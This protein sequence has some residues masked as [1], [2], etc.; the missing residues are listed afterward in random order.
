MATVTSV[1]KGG[2]YGL[3]AGLI[4][5][6]F[7]VVL[8]LPGAIIRISG[9]AVKITATDPTTWQL[10]N[11]MV[12]L[13]YS[14]TWLFLAIGL[15]IAFPG[16]LT[17]IIALTTSGVDRGQQVGL[18][19]AFTACLKAAVS[20]I[21]WFLIIAI[22]FSL[23]T[24]GI[25]T[26][27]IISAQ[28]LGATLPPGDMADLMIMGSNE[29]YAVLLWVVVLASSMAMVLAPAGCVLRAGFDPS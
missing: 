6:I 16:A 27:G 22:P 3:I 7:L 1:L 15:V 11:D 13:G 5:A 20:A 28:V 25:I 29:L 19:G 21:I 12:N 8:Y 23:I 4:W 9:R 18:R 10:G 2:W 24:G 17:S 14:V 26:I